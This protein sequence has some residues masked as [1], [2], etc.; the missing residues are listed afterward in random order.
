MQEGAVKLYEGM[1]FQRIPPYCECPEDDHVCMNM[2]K[3]K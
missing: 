3:K 2:F 1:G